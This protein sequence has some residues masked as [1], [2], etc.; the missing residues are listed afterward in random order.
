MVPVLQ[1]SRR[2]EGNI[3]LSGSQGG[4]SG[5]GLPAAMDSGAQVFKQLQT[6]S[7]GHL[8]TCSS[9]KCDTLLCCACAKDAWFLG[10]MRC[11]TTRE[12][13]GGAR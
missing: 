9:L 5:G 3:A 4:W 12:E 1:C 2:K 6:E 10:R 13:S 11:V 8:P 7:A